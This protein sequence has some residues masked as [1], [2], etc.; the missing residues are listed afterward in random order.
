MFQLLTFSQTAATWWHTRAG[1]H[2]APCH[3]FAA[4]AQPGVCCWHLAPTRVGAQPVC[5]LLREP[6]VLGASAEQ[7]GEAAKPAVAP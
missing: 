6:W 2:M 3:R 4:T 1:H 5:L 7:P